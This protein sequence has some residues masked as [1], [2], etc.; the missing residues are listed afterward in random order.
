MTAAGV[1][2]NATVCFT[3]PQAL[4]VARGR[5]AR[6]AP[7]RGAGEDVERDV[8]RSARSWSA[9]STTGCRC[10]P[11]KLGVL[12]TP[13]VVNWA[14]IACVKRAYGIYHERGYRTR[15]L[16][17]AYRNHLHWSQLIGGDIVLTIPYKWQRSVQRVRHRGRA[18]LRRPGARRRSSPSSRRSCPTS[19]APTSPTASRSTSSTRSARPG[20]RC[21]A[22]SRSYQDLVAVVRDVMLPN[23]DSE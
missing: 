14:G 6:P 5:R 12:L 19:G 11:T 3:V 9:V 15:L 1:S 22:S 21:A 4:A 17:A 10:T 2:V 13:G 7:A 18:A 8:A 20:A 23:P 16:A